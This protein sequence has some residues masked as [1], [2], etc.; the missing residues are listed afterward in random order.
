MGDHD[1]RLNQSPT[2][3]AASAPEN[4]YIIDGV[5]ST[6]PRYG[7]SGTNLTMNFVQEV[8]VMTGGYQAEYGRS[9]GGVF[10]VITKSGG[11]AFHGDLFSY[12]RNKT[13]TPSDVDRRQNKEL[14]TFADRDRYYD[15]GGSIGGPIV[16]DKLWFFGAYR[17][18]QPTV[19]RRRHVED[20]G[21]V[22]RDA[23]RQASP[24]STP[25]RSRGRRRAAIRWSS[26]RSAI[27]R[28][29]KAG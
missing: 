6:D 28:P 26:R 22:N 24:T 3:G 18:Q 17:P 11:N 25:A 23:V 12:F 5:S 29:V 9:T 14:V 2:V 21:A 4:N 19:Y 1:R 20:V 13:W 10:N 15:F 8:Q 27:R 16:R 7:T